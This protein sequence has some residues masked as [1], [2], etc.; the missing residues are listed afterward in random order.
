VHFISLKLLLN[1]DHQS[2]PPSKFGDHQSQLPSKFSNNHS[3]VGFNNIL[4]YG[5]EGV[6]VVYLVHDK[7]MMAVEPARGD[8]G[9]KRCGRA[10]MAS[11]P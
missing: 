2:Q 8:S 4:F 10:L 1:L 3:Y 6:D 5:T 11:A 9:V 7:G